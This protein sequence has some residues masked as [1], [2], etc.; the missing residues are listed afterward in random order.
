M[1]VGAPKALPFS[2]GPSPLKDATRNEGE[3]SHLHLI[4]NFLSARLEVFPPGDSI[5]CQVDNIN[6]GEDSNTPPL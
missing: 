4:Y 2:P 3:F 1:N 5:C 6:R